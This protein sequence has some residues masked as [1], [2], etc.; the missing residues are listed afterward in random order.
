MKQTNNI[1]NLE[2]TMSHAYV[3]KI[4]CK[5]LLTEVELEEYADLYFIDGLGTLK[6]EFMG[7][8]TYEAENPILDIYYGLSGYGRRF[9]AAGIP[10]QDEFSA[11]TE[12]VD[13]LPEIVASQIDYDVMFASMV[14]ISE[15]RNTYDK[16]ET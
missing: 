11:G 8:V 5:E 9:F 4:P 15:R 2:M 12:L 6:V 7:F 1:Y 3:V 16:Y 13:M 10:M 14:P